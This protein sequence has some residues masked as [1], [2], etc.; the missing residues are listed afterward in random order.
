M[1]KFNTILGIC[2]I[3]LITFSISLSFADIPNPRQQIA[4]G[5]EPKNIQCNN[6]MV[7]FLRENRSPICIKLDTMEKLVERQQ[8]TADKQITKSNQIVE[9]K[10]KSPTSESNS[11]YTN[12]CPIDNFLDVSNSDGAGASY[13][14]PYLNVYCDKE[15]VYVRS[16]GI[17]NYSFVQTTPNVL[18]EQDY[19]WKI[20]LYPKIAS[21]SSEIPLLGVIGFAVNG[22]PIYGPNEGPFPDPYGDPVYN[23]LL[24]RCLGHTAQR[25]DYHYHA[26]ELS[27]LALNI[28]NYKESPILGY[29][30]DGFPIYGPYGCIDNCTKIIEFQSSWV[31]KGDPKTYAWDNY[32]YISNN[33]PKYLDKCNGRYDD[34]LGYHYRATKDF[35]YLLGCYS[36]EVTT[37]IDQQHQNLINPV[38]DPPQDKLQNKIS[39]GCPLPGNPPPK[40]GL[41][42]GCPL[43]KNQ[44]PR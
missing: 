12:L 7:L 4:Q 9:S 15:F 38:N 20:P 5:I 25:G 44:P 23:K 43:P 2:S 31:K 36:G 14:K 18:K 29:A 10:N 3:I 35:P 37:S 13:P 41:P 16:N 33:D 28:G 21:Q 30:L 24:D 26:F 42:K 1:N 8:I 6:S 27:C 40:D 32:E 34:K 22:L 39:D 11:A 17:P 19:L